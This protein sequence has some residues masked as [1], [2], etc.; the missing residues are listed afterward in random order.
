MILCKFPRVDLQR[1]VGRIVKNKFGVS[2]QTDLSAKLGTGA[3][4]F[5]LNAR[6]ENADQRDEKE[7]ASE[8]A[9]VRSS[10]RMAT[11]GKEARGTR[12]RERDNDT[13]RGGWLGE[14]K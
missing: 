11:R 8:R 4:H 1:Y 9:G 7:G 6:R 3:S 12:R 13:H 14:C 10:E 5:V 2:V